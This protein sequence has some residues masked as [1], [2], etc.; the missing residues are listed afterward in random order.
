M[1]SRGSRTRAWRPPRPT[2]P[3]YPV[4]LPR[5]CRLAL[6]ATLHHLPGPPPRRLTWPCQHPTPQPTQPPPACLVP[7]CHSCSAHPA[8]LLCYPAPAHHVHCPALPGRVGGDACHIRPTPAL[9]HAL[10]PSSYPCP[11]SAQPST[12]A[13]QHSA[14]GAAAAPPPGP[15]EGHC[16]PQPRTRNRGTRDSPPLCINARSA[17]DVQKCAQTWP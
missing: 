10:C 16:Q 1:C 4:A 9:C 6:R 2:D 12:P 11:H 7:C 8:M 5:P 13:P 3:V 14:L 15:K 17:P